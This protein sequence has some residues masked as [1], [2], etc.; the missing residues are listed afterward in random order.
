MSSVVA[1]ASAFA[2]S[3][4]R[5]HASFRAF[6]SLPFLFHLNLRTAPLLTPPYD[7]H[8]RRQHR[9]GQGHA[10]CHAITGFAS[11]YS[12]FHFRHSS[13]FPFYSFCPCALFDYHFILTLTHSL[14]L[15]L[16]LRARPFFCCPRSALGF[17]FP[18]LYPVHLFPRSA[19][20][21][22]HPRGLCAIRVDHEFARRSRSTPFAFLFFPISTF[23][24]PKLHFPAYLLLPV[25]RTQPRMQC[26]QT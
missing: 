6:P 20:A 26:K 4:E 21:D 19:L 7:S 12:P 5:F 15:L 24:Q 9:Q 17:S 3:V 10:H 2:L 8:R 18:P 1:F 25:T 23:A 16:A 11:V 13:L 22:R 14:S